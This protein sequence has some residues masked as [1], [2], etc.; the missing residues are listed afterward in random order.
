MTVAA[1]MEDRERV[2]VNLVAGAEA[3]VVMVAAA[4]RMAAVARVRKGMT[5]ATAHRTGTLRSSN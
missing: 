5:A 2:A 1:V 3:E 4:E